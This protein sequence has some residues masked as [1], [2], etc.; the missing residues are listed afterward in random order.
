MLKKIFSFFHNETDWVNKSKEQIDSLLAEISNTK[1]LSTAT[2]KKIEAELSSINQKLE[3]VKTQLNDKSF[4]VNFISDVINAKPVLT[5]TF[6]KYQSLLYNDYMRYAND[7]DS[8]AEEARSLIELQKVEDD[9]R[10]MTYDDALLNKTIVAIAGSFSSG[11]S[12]FM[13]SFFNSRKVK[14]P[15][16]MDQTTAISS[17]VMNG[18]DA[19]I[20][21][22]SHQGGRVQIPEKVFELFS[23]GKIEEFNFNMKQLIHHIVFKNT[24][25]KDF[26]YLCFIDTPGFNPGQETESDHDTATSAI[27]NANALLWCFDCSA[28]TLKDDE[29]DILLTIQEKNPDLKIY[30]VANKADL[31]SVD[32]CEQIL[33]EVEMQLQSAVIDF[34]GIGLYSSNTSFINQDINLSYHKGCSIQ[35]FLD[36]CNVQN[37]YKALNMLKK[38]DSVFDDY[39][40]ADKTRIEKHQK[41]IRTLRIFEN[42]FTEIND[43]KDE[44]L[45]Y[46]KTR[47]DTKRYK[48]LKEIK[49]TTDDEAELFESINNLKK[50]FNAVIDKDT[51]DIKQATELCDNMKTAVMQV[52]SLREED[53][54]TNELTNNETAGLSLDK[55]ITVKYCR[56]CG[57][58][59]AI[60]QYFCTKCGKEISQ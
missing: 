17:Y 10:L 22:F 60:D 48:D 12:S 33:D 30:I 25:V 49:D 14:L 59:V 53:I 13:N 4:K 45:Q 56:N 34:C 2:I 36:S 16:G 46:Y 15:T 50:D 27:A 26:E 58:E 21:G 35:E 42:T 28:G 20:T 19:N 40:N 11:K 31:K 44:Q 3:L 7:N 8:F 39:I 1:K 51:K 43:T 5:E 57:N 47:A 29:I 9:L 37:A 54:C 32:E 6:Q 23:Y 18:N 38:I 52:F 55:N 41:I 24:F